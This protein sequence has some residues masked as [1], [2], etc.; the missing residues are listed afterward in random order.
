MGASRIVRGVT[1]SGNIHFW[2][3]ARRE[4]W[5]DLAWDFIFVLAVPARAH[6]KHSNSASRPS[7]TNPID[8]EFPTRPHPATAHFPPQP[9][10][11]SVPQ[12]LRQPAS[13]SPLW[14]VR[15]AV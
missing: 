9:H 1:L 10:G 11:F 3:T 6:Q 15:K 2:R 8:L 5:N 7:F 4:Y 12:P 13:Q 14:E